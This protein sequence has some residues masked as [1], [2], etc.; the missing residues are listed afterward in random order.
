[1]KANII[2]QGVEIQDVQGVELKLIG[3]NHAISILKLLYESKNG[4]RFKT[5]AYGLMQNPAGA[6]NLLKEMVKAGWV[7]HERGELY[8]ITRK[9]G[10]V[11]EAIRKLPD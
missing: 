11:Y 8:H 6:S 5:I 10:E 9:G 2:N 3:R 7:E 4:V 1:M